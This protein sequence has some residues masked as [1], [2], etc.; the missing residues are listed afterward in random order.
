MT[1]RSCPEPTKAAAQ[2]TEPPKPLKNPRYSQDPSSA[3]DLSDLLSCITKGNRKQNK[4]ETWNLVVNKPD[5]TD[6][7]QKGS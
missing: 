4:N 1:L 5:P 7:S 6:A 3:G 2:P